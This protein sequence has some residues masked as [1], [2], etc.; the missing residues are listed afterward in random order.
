MIAIATTTEYIEKSALALL[1]ATVLA[2]LITILFSSPTLPSKEEESDCDIDLSEGFTLREGMEDPVG[3]QIKDAFEK[4]FNDMKDK[5][6]KPI[7]EITDFFKKIKE[8]FESIP[9]RINN[10]TNAFKDVGDGI[11]LEFENLGKSLDLGFNDVASLLGSAT[12][13]GINKIKNFRN[14]ILYY[15]L[16][17]IG[18]MIY[19][20]VIEF[21]L[22]ILKLATGGR[23]DG[24]KCV[25]MVIDIFRQLDD[26][27]YKSSG[28][29]FMHFPDSVITMCYYCNFDE[30]V[31][32]LTHDWND[33]IPNMLNEPANKF[34]EAKSKF[35]SVFK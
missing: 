17:W 32:K 16:D 10:F 8:V 14:C 28:T 29:H 20:V 18:K 11:K 25:N 3:K 5:M 2:I 23:V 24:H 19:G 35:E 33:T 21:P 26:K 4:P 34:S 7:N 31:A 6:M 9:G 30:E 12:T 27:L 22:F 1:G 13:C 15:M